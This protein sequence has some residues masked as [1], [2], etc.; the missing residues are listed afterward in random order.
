HA[1]LTVSY[2][3]RS[4]LEVKGIIINGYRVDQ[5]TM[6]EQTSPEV[7][8]GM[9]GIPILGIVPFLPEVNVESGRAG[10]LIEVIEE[11]VDWRR[12]L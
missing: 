10:N 6:A 11:K 9:I 8:R 1:V 7:I 2:A 5:A 12:L 3:Q 4:G